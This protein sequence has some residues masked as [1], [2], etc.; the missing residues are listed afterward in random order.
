M[1]NLFPENVKKIDVKQSFPENV[2]KIDVKQ[3]GRG[4]LSFFIFLSVSENYLKGK[5]TF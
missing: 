2:K 3:S 4:L 1:S 5:E